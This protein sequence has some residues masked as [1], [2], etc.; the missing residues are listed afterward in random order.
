MK[1]L[2]IAMLLSLALLVGCFTGEQIKRVDEGMSPADVKRIVG[3]PDGLER[4]ENELVLKYTNKI[5]SG[6]GMDKAD[7]FFIFKEDKLTQWGAG[8]VRQNQRSDGVIFFV[9]IYD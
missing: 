4:T 5:I 9:P 8:T 3:K 7:Y 6:W 2:I 1:K